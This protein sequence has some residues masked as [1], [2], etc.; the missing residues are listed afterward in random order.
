MNLIENNVELQNNLL[1]FIYE[2]SNGSL[3]IRISISDIY[4]NFKKF[5]NQNIYDTL[6]FLIKKNYID[7]ES[8]DNTGYYN[9][10]LTHEGKK[11][12]ELNFLDKEKNMDNIDDL[13]KKIGS[14]KNLLS[15]YELAK[16]SANEINN[17]FT[18]GYPSWEV[19][20]HPAESLPNERHV[21]WFL[22]NSHQQGIDVGKYQETGQQS[23]GRHFV[24]RSNPILGQ[25]LSQ[26]ENLITKTKDE[27]ELVE[28]QINQLVK[29]K[30]KKKFES[31]WIV[32]N[33]WKI[34]GTILT[35]IAIAIALLS[36]LRK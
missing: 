2:K 15:L 18:K 12:I 14:T 19:T 35:I 8:A 17:H 20:L 7:G 9:F 23:N 6:L 3:S 22:F 16:I 29:N 13:K 36:Y 32:K 4:T 11:V 34:V 30:K 24:Y 25:T 1:N 5:N 26:L 27:I 21:L 31:L 10:Q 28:I 33:S